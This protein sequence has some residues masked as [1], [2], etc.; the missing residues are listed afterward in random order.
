MAGNLCSSPTIGNL[1]TMN[2][3]KKAL[4]LQKY[5]AETHYFFWPCCW[6][7]PVRAV[8]VANRNRGPAKDSA[9]PAQAGLLTTDSIQTGNDLTQKEEADNAW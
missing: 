9:A 6:F 7:L 5:P 2:L 1:L 8:R 4:F 3:S